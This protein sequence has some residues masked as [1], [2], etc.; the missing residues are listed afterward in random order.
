MGLVWHTVLSDTDDSRELC[1]FEFQ[2]QR[3]SNHK[4]ATKQ[5]T[6][7]GRKCLVSTCLNTQKVF[8]KTNNSLSAL[9]LLD[10]KYGDEPYRSPVKLLNITSELSKRFHQVEYMPQFAPLISPWK[11][12]NVVDSF[13]VA[14]LL[15]QILDPRRRCCVD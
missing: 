2:N 1:A 14:K 7:Q 6:R 15:I 3:E 8:H 4:Y 11:L 5:M 12:A 9:F 10:F 13:P